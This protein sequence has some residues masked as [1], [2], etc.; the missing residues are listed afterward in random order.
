ME[1]NKKGYIYV[2]S[3]PRSGTTY[4]VRLLEIRYGFWENN[5]HLL[6]KVWKEH[7]PQ[8]L[9][10]EIPDTLQ[11][12]IVRDPIDCLSSATIKDIGDFIQVQKPN[13]DE[14][15]DLYFKHKVEGYNRYLDNLIKNQNNVMGVSFES[16]TSSSPE[17]I[18]KIDSLTSFLPINNFEESY[19]RS[20]NAMKKSNNHNSFHNNYP[21]FKPTIYEGYK[22][23]IQSYKNNVLKETYE[24]YDYLK[25]EVLL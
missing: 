25:S 15:Y 13:K 23:K 16:V 12:S 7:F 17:L 18:K 22:E 14:F 10:A 4:F 2:N 3:H 21:M 6:T 19:Q 8:V 1:N 20:I 11:I 24:K 9:L 5:N